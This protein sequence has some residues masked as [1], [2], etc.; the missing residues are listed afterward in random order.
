MPIPLAWVW[1]HERGARLGLH[2]HLLMHVPGQYAPRLGK[3]ICRFLERYTGRALLKDR[4]DGLVTFKADEPRSAR[5]VIPQKA[6]LEFQGQ[7][8]RYMM[9]GVDPY[10]MVPAAIVCQH[11]QDL[12]SVLKLYRVEDQGQ[13]QGKRCGYSVHNLGKTAFAQVATR[14]RL[15]PDEPEY[16]MAES[17]F[18]FVDAVETIRGLRA[19]RIY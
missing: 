4:P 16:I 14:L 19:L 13:I 1:C 12:L 3:I 2:T 5:G 17:G 6:A 8:I 7:I 10:A 15:A 11:G 18:A 9:K